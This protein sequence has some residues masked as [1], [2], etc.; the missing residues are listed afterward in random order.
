M[1]FEFPPEPKAEFSDGESYSERHVLGL[2]APLR[3]WEWI[4]AQLP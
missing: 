4:D 2:G 1:R 3:A